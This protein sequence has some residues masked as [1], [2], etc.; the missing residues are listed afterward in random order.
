M[1][2]TDFRLCSNSQHLRCIR[3]LIS[4]AQLMRKVLHIQI[5]MEKFH[6]ARNIGRE[7]V[8][9]KL[10]VKIEA[11]ASSGLNLYAC[12]HTIYSDCDC[13]NVMA[14]KMQQVFTSNSLVEGHHYLLVDVD[15][16]V[17]ILHITIIQKSISIS[18]YKIRGTGE[19]N[20]Y[21]ILE[22]EQFCS[23]PFLQGFV[24]KFTGS[25]YSFCQASSDFV[26]FCAMSSRHFEGQDHAQLYAK[27]RPSP[28]PTLVKI[29]LNFLREK[30][31]KLFPFCSSQKKTFL[32]DYLLIYVPKNQAFGFTY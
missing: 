28:P 12:Q 23:Y 17:I 4:Y 10:A 30:V 13:F 21:P 19:F 7:S 16:S 18:V 3:Y 25:A 9:Y 20:F 15:L 26:N 27:Y 8:L 1:L 11:P 31:R 22:V 5:N 14:R 6:R 2:F 29:L 24:S 32:V